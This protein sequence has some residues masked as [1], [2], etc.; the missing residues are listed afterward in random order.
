MAIRSDTSLW[1]WGASNASSLGN[2]SEASNVPIPIGRAQDT[3][4][5]GWTRVAAGDH[6]TVGIRDGSLYNWG[7][8]LPGPGGTVQWPTRIDIDGTWTHI[9]AG[10]NYV[11]AIREG[12]ARYAWGA[13]TAAG[14]G[15]S[16]TEAEPAQLTP[17]QIA[18]GEA[19][20]W[21]SIAANFNHSLGVRGGALYAWG[22]NLGNSVG[23]GTTGLGAA[24]N[25][26]TPR[27]LGTGGW[28]QV[29]VG[30][31]RTQL[32]RQFSVGIRNG[33]LYAW[34]NNYSGRTG[35]GTTTGNTTTPTRVRF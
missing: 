12:G 19:G 25:H 16:A 21:Q 22:Q 9:A 35:L 27:Q 1:G 2:G 24:A 28:T 5:S 10:I 31:S 17:A 14:L 34:G 6:F 29:S 11:L 20:N 15:R 32:D 13:L 8:G 7:S 23:S 18:G 3:T 30:G 33:H 4:L 26:H